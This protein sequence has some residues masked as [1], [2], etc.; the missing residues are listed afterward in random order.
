MFYS[1]TPHELFLLDLFLFL[2]LESKRGQQSD[3][4]PQQ[5]GYQKQD[6][7]RHGDREEQDVR[8]HRIGVLND[9]DDSEDG[10]DGR[11]DQFGFVHDGYE[12]N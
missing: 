1:Q 7:T 8:F 12:L 11:S 6:E 3:G 9:D 2:K 10:D 4:E 5:C